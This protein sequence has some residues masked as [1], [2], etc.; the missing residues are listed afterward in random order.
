V[1]LAIVVVG[2]AAKQNS[3][4]PSGLRSTFQGSVEEFS[5]PGVLLVVTWAEW[6][7]VWKLLKPELEAF[8]ARAPTDVAFLIVNVD[9]EP[10]IARRLGATIV[11][12]VV[13]VKAGATVEVLPNF[14]SAEELSRVVSK[15]LGS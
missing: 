14:T 11:P 6:A 2:C 8:Q 13:V 12:S 10:A 4:P 7:S 1:V 3:S 5:G 9:Q 15:W